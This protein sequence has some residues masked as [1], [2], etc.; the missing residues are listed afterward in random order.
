MYTCPTLVTYSSI[1]LDST[2]SKAKI[3]R[4]V[5]RSSMWYAMVEMV[6]SGDLEGDPMRGD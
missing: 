2:R 4:L 5:G 3:R 1:M 6:Q